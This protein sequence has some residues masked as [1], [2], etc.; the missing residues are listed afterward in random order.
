MGVVFL[1]RASLRLILLLVMCC[2]TWLGSMSTGLKNETGRLIGTGSPVSAHLQSPRVGSH[3]SWGSL[4]K[5]ENLTRP[6]AIG[7]LATGALGVL[8]S[9]NLSG[10]HVAELAADLTLAL[11]AWIF[12]RQRVSHD[13]L[14][15]RQLETNASDHAQALAAEKEHIAEALRTK[16]HVEA[17]IGHEIRNSLNGL[18]GTLNLALMT[19][20]TGE[21]REYLELSKSSA[22]SLQALLVDLSDFSAT[23]IDDLKVSQ[24]EFPLEQAVRGSIIAVHD[25]ARKKELSV[26]VE[27]AK[28]VPN[29][30]VGD[31]A[32]LHQVLIKILENAVKFSSDG[33]ILVTVQRESSP[34]GAGHAEPEMVV[35]VFS[36]RDWGIGIP[37]DKRE[38]ILEPFQ[39]VDNSTTRKYAG[40]GLGLTLCRQLVRLMDGRIWVESEMGHGSTFRFTAKFQIGKQATEDGMHI[41]EAPQARHLGRLQVLLVEDNRVNQVVTKRFLEKRGFHCLVANNGREAIEI[42]NGAA[43]DLILMDVQMPEMDGFE[44]TRC[45]REL[46]MEIGVHVPILALTAHAKEGDREKC[47]AAGMDGYVSKP[48]QP[49]ELYKA[50]DVLLGSCEVHPGARMSR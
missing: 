1:T 13:N 25:S 46:E 34:D 8:T 36:V 7:T 2:Q 22:E 42:L 47:L 35:L 24:V 5:R 26:R 30:L 45:I 50:I 29:R 38:L 41:G 17:N 4:L 18:L 20:L 32:R 40:A 3:K 15:K 44:A 28:D 14:R 49:N 48:V 10:R 33:E 27:I 11:M 43:A 21:Q 31:P 16:S 19:G 23:A 6:H 39:Q 12:W 37:D 9:E